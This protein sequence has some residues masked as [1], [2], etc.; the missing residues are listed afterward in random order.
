MPRKLGRQA[1]RG[2]ERSYVRCQSIACADKRLDLPK[3]TE[4]EGK[5][6]GDGSTRGGT[7]GDAPAR[8]CP[9]RGTYTR[10]AAG[11]CRPRAS[12]PPTRVRRVR[13]A[14]AR[15]PIQQPRPSCAAPVPYTR[16]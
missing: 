13:T 2:K 7:G 5:A 6:N 4:S 10:W 9:F 11:L 14:R 16:T 12:K 3:E 15:Q 1:P 8:A